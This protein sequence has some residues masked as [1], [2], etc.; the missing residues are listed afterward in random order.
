MRYMK[1]IQIKVEIKTVHFLFTQ[2]R[3]MI[4]MIKK[5]FLNIIKDSRFN[6]YQKIFMEIRLQR[7]Q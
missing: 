4:T 2:L 7:I 1:N 6:H 3:N 5:I